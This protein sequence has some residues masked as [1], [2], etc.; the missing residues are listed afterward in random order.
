M[1]HLLFVTFFRN[2]NRNS[3]HLEYIKATWQLFRFALRLDILNSQ[4]LLLGM[5]NIAFNFCKRLEVCL[6]KLKY[7]TLE[8]PIKNVHRWYGSSNREDHWCVCARGRHAEQC[9][10]SGLPALSSFTKAR[11]EKCQLVL[12]WS[13]NKIPYSGYWTSADGNKSL[14]ET[15]KRSWSITTVAPRWNKL[16]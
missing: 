8:K 6:L 3:R 1:Q 2:S 15:S 13:W 9:V 7:G 14:H 4:A 12:Y 11:A 16:V 10:L 5:K